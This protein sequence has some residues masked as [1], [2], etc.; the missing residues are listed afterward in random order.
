MAIHFNQ[1]LH[2]WNV[3]RVENFSYQF[4]HALEFNQDLSPWNT[5]NAINLNSMFL[6][7]NSFVHGDAILSQWEIQEH[8][9]T[10]HMC[11]WSQAI[12]Y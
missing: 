5:Q 8:A 2:H 11:Q 7:A 9:D 1:P 6:G 12:M 3:S 4:L 10:E